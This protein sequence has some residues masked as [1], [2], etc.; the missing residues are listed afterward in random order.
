MENPKLITSGS[1]GR[2]KLFSGIEKL[3][4]AVKSTLGPLGNTVILESPN[5][6]RGL[7]VTK[8]GVT[9]AKSIS[10]LDPIENLAVRMMKEAAD[11]TASQAGDGTTTAILIT[12]AI[13]KYGME[14]LSNFP[15]L[16]T[17][18]FTRS[19]VEISERVIKELEGLSRK[20]NKGNLKDVATIS[21]NN[22]KEL[23]EMIAHAY[24]T[25][26]KNGVVTVEK[27]QTSKTYFEHTNGI[28]VK[29]GYSSNSFVNDQRKDECIL[30]DVLVLV[31]GQEINNLLSIERVLK[32]VI[33]QGKKL[34]IIGE[35]SQ[36]VINTLAANVV[37]NGL[38]FCNIQPPNFGYKQKEMMNDIALSVGA[39]Y[40]SEDTGDNLEMITMDD[41]GQVD[42]MISSKDE[43]ILIGSSKGSKSDIEARILELYAQMDS[44]P[45]E[46]DKA[47]ILDRIAGLNGAIGV[48]YVGGESDIEQ[49]ERYDR[50]DDA[51]CAVRSA[52]E[53]GILPGGGSALMYVLSCLYDNEV[54]S[55]E[56]RSAR[57]VISSAIRAPFERLV[58]HLDVD[59]YDELYY[60]V[61][62]E[63]NH[64][65][66]IKTGKIGDMFKM[67]VID[68]LK[69]T[70]NA[71]RNA[72]SVGTTILATNAIVTIQRA[73]EEV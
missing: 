27:S 58:D 43:T 10:L 26:G 56:W 35:C 52:I 18:E 25:V 20:V 37:K 3:S 54:D 70:K 5:H 42:K 17:T 55:Q 30:E 47:F 7:T 38:K 44:T 45:S 53:E 73:D 23:G 22:D 59:K 67:G 57:S 61:T 6:T 41:L 33:Q 8:D 51:V 24:D 32:P 46:T 28:K 29:R 13:I 34:L 63:K 21:S 60:Y 71:L 14:E 39:K 50:V 16:N 4:N 1:E 12:E 36:N 19:V 49:K 48:I 72:V 31:T 15:E 9:V 68:P 64:G 62:K 66:N 11:R 69:V 2:N 40:F 65:M